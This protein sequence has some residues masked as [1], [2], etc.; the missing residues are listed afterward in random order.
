MDHA[1][2]DSLSEDWVSQP[3][4]SGSPAPSLPSLSNSTTNSSSLQAKSSRIPKFNPQKQAWTAPIDS[5]S[6]LSERSVNDHNLP[7]SQR[8]LRRPSKLRGEISKSVRGRQHSRTFSA[9]TTHSTQ[10]HTVQHKSTSLSPKKSTYETPEWKRRLLQGD[11]A[12]GEQ[13][14]LFSPAGLESI[15][16]PPPSARRG[17]PNKEKAGAL[18]EGALC[19]H[20][21][22]RYTITAAKQ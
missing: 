9:S 2:L 13:R 10:V 4:S 5:N 18:D 21:A 12:Y 14:D 6:P 19:F 20:Q 7:L 3:R 17:F 22:L 16:H 11:V 8:D 15:F 1:W